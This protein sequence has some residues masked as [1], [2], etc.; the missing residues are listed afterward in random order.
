MKI[1]SILVILFFS[2]SV[3]AGGLIGDAIKS[4]GGDLKKIGAQLDSAHRSSVTQSIPN[5][6]TIEEGSTLSVQSL[7]ALEQAKIESRLRSEAVS[8]QIIAAESKLKDVHTKLDALAKLGLELESEKVKLKEQRDR[9][10]K[11]KSDV[12]QRE[13]LF[14]MGFYASFLAAFVAVF[15]LVVRM[16]TFRLEQKLKLIEI[17]H[18]QLELAQFK[19]SV[20]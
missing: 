4:I 19:E 7:A 17:E 11:E 3:N 9:I 8:Q 2:C 14:S 20:A 10:A 6:K 18:K 5:Y 15:G 13:K 16:P 1:S 12:E